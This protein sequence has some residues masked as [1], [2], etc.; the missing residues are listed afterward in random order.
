MGDGMGSSS[1]LVRRRATMDMT[2]LQHSSL[3]FI[4]RLAQMFSRLQ[5]RAYDIELVTVLLE[6]LCA[7]AM[8]VYICMYRL[9]VNRLFS[10]AAS[11]RKVKPCKC[12]GTPISISMVLA[13][14][15]RN[16]GIV[17]SGICIS[18]LFVVVFS[19]QKQPSAQNVP[20]ARRI[21]G[22]YLLVSVKDTHTA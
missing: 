4:L 9:D 1:A 8:C 17:E 3:R 11:A 19:K 18:P 22:I 21:S 14:S 15:S 13:R 5:S 16:F 10:A 7:F 12:L 20:D 2:R 6:M